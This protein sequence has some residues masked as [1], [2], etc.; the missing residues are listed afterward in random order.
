MEDLSARVRTFRRELREA[1]PRGR[2]RR[3]PDRLRAQV[4]SLGRSLRDSGASW[5]AIG[6]QL[7]VSSETARRMC[8]P[9]SRATA[10]VPVTV[11]PETS[12]ARASM[13]TERGVTLVSP[14][15]WRI[16]GLR[17]SDVVAFM[18]EPK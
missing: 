6:K 18:G 7:G 9:A 17:F 8:V 10:V 16:E 14:S 5:D 13:A 1:G 11:T 12:P 4:R 2:G 15:G 3:F